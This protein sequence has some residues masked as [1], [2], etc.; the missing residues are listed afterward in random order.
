MLI[1]RCSKV[2]FLH[3]FLKLLFIS[4]FILVPLYFGLSFTT[5]TFPKIVITQILVLLMIGLWL[6]QMSLSGEIIIKKNHLLLPMLLYL[7]ICLLSLT[8]S[9]SIAGGVSLLWQVFSYIFLTVIITNNFSE[10]EIQPWALALTTSGFL[11]S[12]YGILQYLGIE[13]FLKGYDYVPRIPFSTLGHRNQVA[14]FLILVIPL[15]GLF[16]FLSKRWPLRFFFLLSS[17]MMIYHLILTRSRGGVLGLL[18]SF[19]IIFTLFVYKIVRKKET[20]NIAEICSG[21]FLS[22]LLGISL[23]LFLLPASLKIHTKEIQ[24]G[25]ILIHALDGSKIKGNGSISIRL[26]YQV[27][28][29]DSDIIG[30]LDLYGKG[31]QSKP[32]SLKNHEK[33]WIVLREKIFLQTPLPHEELYLRW[34]PS[35]E[36]ISIQFRRISVESN[37]SNLIKQKW[38]NDFFS[39]IGITGV[40][41]TLSCQARLYMYLNTLRMIRDN[42]IFGV[43]F[44]NFKYVYPRYRDRKEWVIS[45]INTRVEEAHNEYLQILSEVGLFGFFAFMFIIFRILKMSWKLFH[46]ETFDRSLFL[47]MA[48]SMG[49]LSTLIQCL[50][51][52]NLQNPASGITFWSSV[53]FLEIL[54]QS[55]RAN[56]VIWLINLKGRRFLTYLLTVGILGSLIL[57]IIFSAK[58]LVGDYY[59]KAGRSSIL[60]EDW[61]GAVYYLEKGEKFSPYNFDIPFHLGQI[62]EQLKDYEKAI[63]FYQKSISLHPFFIEAKNNLGVL[64]L[65]TGKIEEAIEE[66]KNAIE[67]NPYHPNLHNNLGYLYSKKNLFNEAL[68]EYLKA[69]ELAPDIPEIYKNIG[70][71]YYKMGESKEAKVYLKKYLFLNPHDSQKDFLVGIIELGE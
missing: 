21:V 8:W 60:I 3:S 45:G 31:F 64:Y 30:F 29:G 26:E 63:E 58:P 53:G 50:F 57:G 55:Q 59:L 65:K 22:L 10:Q 14:Q 25:G 37:G 44:G 15:S 34:I 1:N 40:D 19:S 12:F 7:S 9:T 5:Y 67:I 47:S 23:I 46:K 61:K 11:I 66:F 24:S 62:Y 32:I 71:L 69:N 41:K 4:L 51:D 54:Y 16:C 49:I 6:F 20:L 56:Q 39:R 2:V 36:N 48:L 33:S 13:P 70:L 68:R 42:L 17:L 38:L 28:E 18:L 52:F 27:L 35:K 43:G